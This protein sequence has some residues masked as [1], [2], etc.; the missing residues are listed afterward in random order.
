MGNGTVLKLKALKGGADDRQQVFL[1]MSCNFFLEHYNGADPSGFTPQTMK[2]TTSRNDSRSP[3]LEQMKSFFTTSNGIRF[4]ARSKKC[5]RVLL[6]TGAFLL[7]S[8]A[9]EA[10]L[11]FNNTFD[12]TWGAELSIGQAAVINAESILSSIFV[13]NVS[14]NITFS[15]GSGPGS[16]A[17]ASSTFYNNAYQSYSTLKGDLMNAAAANPSN[18]VLSSVLSYLPV[19]SPTTLKFV[20]PTA[21]AQSLGLGTGGQSSAGTVT[22]GNGTTWDP[23]QS[24]GITAGQGD[25]TGTL[26]HEISHVM[27]RD[28]YAYASQPSPY[29]TPLDLSRYTVGGSFNFTTNNAV[30]STNGGATALADYSPTSDTGDWG[31]AL[32]SNNDANNAFFSY[33]VKQQWT[34][35]DT[36]VMQAIGWEI[37]AVPE[38]STFALFGLGALV[39]VIAYRRKLA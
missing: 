27:G 34:S 30:F 15:Y 13:N 38:P 25:L 6:V 3:I 20:I 8:S 4:F 18:T 12:G 33:G 14:L 1:L 29:L 21:N 31:G 36:K 16:G 11:T 19:S 2:K 10:G 23:T 32:T 17:Y 35:V 7:G 9:A 28:D 24:N 5:A 37:A 39:L 26:L 22:V